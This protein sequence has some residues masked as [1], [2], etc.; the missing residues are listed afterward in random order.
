ML[1]IDIIAIEQKARRMRAEEIQRMEG[2]VWARLQL[3][4]SL[5]AGSIGSG[6]TEIA[7]AL[8]ALLTSHPRAGRIRHSD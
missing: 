2:L 7:S 6:V 8:R 3:L 5:L 1:P 4:V